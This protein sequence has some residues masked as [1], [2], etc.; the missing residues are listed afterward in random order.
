MLWYIEKEVRLG[1]NQTCMSKPQKWHVPS[2]KQQR[3]H[4]PTM[5]NEIETNKQT[6]KKQGTKKFCKRKTI[7]QAQ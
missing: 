5:L 6:K 4:G 2:K 3:L 7:K 1:N